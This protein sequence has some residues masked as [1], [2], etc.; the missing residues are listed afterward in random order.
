[1]FRD[2]GAFSL[3]LA[4]TAASVATVLI[5]VPWVSV[6]AAGLLVLVLPGYG[7]T[8]A[9]FPTRT[10]SLAETAVYILGLSIG[11][12]VL[13]GFVL[14]LTPWGLTKVPWALTL[15]LVAGVSMLVAVR[16]GYRPAGPPPWLSE[17]FS[18]FHATLLVLSALLFVGI[19]M[20]ARLS[21]R[22]RP[23]TTFTQLWLVP[24]ASAQQ[25]TG[26][27]AGETVQV[28]IQNSETVSMSY[29]LVLTV[30]NTIVREWPR[31][32]VS[33]GKQWAET[34]QLSQDTAGDRAAV[35]LY[36]LDSP[37]QVYRQVTL[38]LN[39]ST[40]VGQTGPGWMVAR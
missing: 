26:A 20:S 30:D 19:V 21:E 18:P 4:V 16:R 8:I 35:S 36:R 28:G 13:A 24:L 37:S 15:G 11:C 33:P 38:N 6:V 23:S 9:L 31:I 2:T 22:D 27:N 17:V 32:S 14:N 10:Q 7:L 12:D 5:G 29:R 3:P 40:N 25:A 39:E 34:I 1:M